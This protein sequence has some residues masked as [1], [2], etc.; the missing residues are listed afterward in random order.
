MVARLLTSTTK[1]I[2]APTTLK[3][4]RYRFISSLSMAQASKQYTGSCHC[5]VVKYTVDLEP[6]KLAD[7]KASRCNCTW[8]QKGAITGFDITPSSFKLI[9]PASKSEMGD[10]NPKKDENFHRYFCKECGTH[11]LREGVY[12]FEG[13]NMDAC[14]LNLN[15]LDQPQE[16]LDLSDVKVE[17]YDGKHDNWMAGKQTKPYK[18]GLI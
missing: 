13:Q 7:P 16:G 12:E 15:S 11:I 18:E 14:A 17:Y 1:Y 3:L 4:P 2:F 10:Y 5:G 9:S 6:E 8:C